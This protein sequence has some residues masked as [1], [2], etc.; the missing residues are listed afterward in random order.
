MPFRYLAMLQL[1]YR[2]NPYCEPENTV[3]DR[4]V[5]P[6]HGTPPLA[7]GLAVRSNYGNA[8]PDEGP[9]A[10]KARGTLERV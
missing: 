6:G 5:P 1:L 9:G 4:H 2:M 3:G 8:P 7:C 10:G